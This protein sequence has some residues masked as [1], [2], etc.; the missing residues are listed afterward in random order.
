MKAVVEKYTPEYVQEI[1]GIP[2]PRVVCP[3][4]LARI[5]I[6]IVTAFGRLAGRQPLY[7]SVSLRALYSNRN[8]SHERASRDLDYHPR[9]LRETLIDTFRW[10]EENGYLAGSLKLKSAR[11][12]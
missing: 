8:I 9:P 4:W 7:T 11:S 10:F 2:A 3:I 5:S 1:T 6:P 12:L